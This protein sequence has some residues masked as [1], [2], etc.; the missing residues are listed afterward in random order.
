MILSEQILRDKILGCFNGKNAGGTLGAPFEC[1]RGT[2]PVDYYTQKDIDHNPPPNDDLDLQLCWLNAVEV[3]GGKITSD[4]LADYWETYI[5]PAWS[6]YGIAKS[7]LRAGLRPPFSGKINNYF[8]VSNGA[9]IRSEIWACLA[10]GNP[11]QAVSYAYLDATVDHTGDGV[12]AEMFFA[13]L[14]S[15]A[16]VESNK[17][18][19]IDIGLSYIP[20]DCGVTKAVRFVQDCYKNGLD[21]E[22]ARIKMMK[23]FPSSFG[24]CFDNK[25]ERVRHNEVLELPENPIGDDV[26]NATA[27]VILAWYYSEGDFGE[28]IKLATYCGEDADCTTATVGAIMGIIAGDSALPEKWIKPLGNIIKVGCMSWS[29][30]GWPPK[31]TDELTDRI[32]NAIPKALDRKLYSLNGG[33]SVVAKEGDLLYCEPCDQFL[34]NGG[35]DVGKFHFTANEI[36]EFG[37]YALPYN[38]DL[39]KAV[40]ELEKEPF[41]AEDEELKFTVKVRDIGLFKMQHMVDVSVY[42]DTGVKVVGASKKTVP[43]HNAYMQEGVCSFTLKAE[44]LVNFDNTIIVHFGIRGRHLSYTATFKLLNK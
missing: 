28:A 12:W 23:D 41:I 20:K 24:W 11:E 34:K 1:K 15:A 27:T 21:F 14:Q 8:G 32:I 25:S 17:E 35:R 9:Y 42:T 43:I 22:S 44:G 26:I 38:F 7:N 19:L 4:I 30:C 13:G 2:F 16:F 10:P 29:Y 40:I 39:F 5:I 36:K 33:V 18:K 31:S 3:Y 37:E 6:E